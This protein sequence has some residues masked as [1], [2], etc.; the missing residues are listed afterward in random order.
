VEMLFVARFIGEKSP[1]V[2]PRYQGVT[3][4]IKFTCFKLSKS[5]QN[6]IQRLLMSFD[7]IFQMYLVL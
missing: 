5:I 6:I 2:T 7:K 1:L 3:V 4:H